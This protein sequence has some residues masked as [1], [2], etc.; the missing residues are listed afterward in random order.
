MAS[1]ASTNFEANKVDIDRLWAIHE[2]I[3]G[4]GPGRKHDVEV[5]NRSAIVFITACWEAYVEDVATEAFDFLLAQAASANVIPAKVRTLASK[6]LIEAADKRRVWE[7]ADGGW[8]TVLA[9]HRGAVMDRW[10]ASLNTP[11]ARQVDDLFEDLVGL[12]ALSSHWSWQSMSAEN[13][14][15]KL[16]GYIT[17]RGQIA[18]RVHHDDT[19]YKSW[20]TDFLHHVEKLVEKTDKVVSEHLLSLVNKSPW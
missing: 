19:V 13:A 7:L 4:S 1:T 6:E 14:K 16:D 17:A 10:V 18:H 5:L 9:N 11:K 15:T 12:A 20:G 2:T 8:R 3:A